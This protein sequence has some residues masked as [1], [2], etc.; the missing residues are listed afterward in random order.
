MQRL[1]IRF[2]AFLHQNLPNSIKSSL[3]DNI[4]YNKK[5]TTQW[6][7]TE[8]TTE[9]S[10]NEKVSCKVFYHRIDREIKSKRCLNKYQGFMAT[11]IIS[12][13]YSELLSGN[14]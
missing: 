1:I 4:H 6:P 8:N 9:T 7:I 12:F 14:R 5:Q 2:D 13:F 10:I 3:F 11:T